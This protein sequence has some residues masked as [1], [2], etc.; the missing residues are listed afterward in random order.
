MLSEL[1]CFTQPPSLK[2]AA[3]RR[4]QPDRAEH[5]AGQGDKLERVAA[6]AAHGG[7]G[8]V[9]RGLLAVGVGGAISGVA[10]DASGAEQRH[11]YLEQF[12]VTDERTDK[13]E[14]E[15]GRNERRDGGP[16]LRADVHW[17]H[18]LR[19][20]LPRPLDMLRGICDYVPMTTTEQT[21]TITVPANA[22]RLAAEELFTSIR[23][24][25]DQDQ[26]ALAELLDSVAME[27][28]RAGWEAAGV[29]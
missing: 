27:L 17:V 29:R 18:L 8:K 21:V 20:N 3:K 23:E 2:R 1:R 11:A 26:A 19:N 6:S 5:D 13:D 22:A 25:K 4:R 28:W 24:A 10:A 12:V 15:A 7:A 9:H 14:D 16:H